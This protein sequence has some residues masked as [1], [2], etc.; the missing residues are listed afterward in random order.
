[1]IIFLQL[2]GQW[3]GGRKSADSQVYTPLTLPLPLHIPPESILGWLNWHERP[4]AST[5]TTLRVS[6]FQWPSSFQRHLSWQ[7]G[8]SFSDIINV[9][10][11]N[12][13]TTLEDN[14]C[15]NIHII[16]LLSIIVIIFLYL[17]SSHS[18]RENLQET[19]QENLN[20]KYV[21]VARLKIGKKS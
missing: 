20:T 13:N 6:S 18:G 15:S 3:L 12:N 4:A 10:L 21:E 11:S 2:R 19:F 17:I 8:Y 14:T 1:M 9:R 7:S 16:I 5:T